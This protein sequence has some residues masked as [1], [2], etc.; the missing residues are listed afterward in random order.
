M[1]LGLRVL[2]TMCSCKWDD[3][4]ITE[5]AG[6]D[7]SGG[8]LAGFIFG[9][10]CFQRPQATFGGDGRNDVFCGFFYFSYIGGWLCWYPCQFA[11]HGSSKEIVWG[12]A[13]TPSPNGIVFLYLFFLDTIMSGFMF[14][15][16][17]SP[18]LS[19][20]LRKDRKIICAA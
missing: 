13:S 1:C 4:A 14:G 9:A 2:Q 17:C 20:N 7:G 3:P 10:G 19:E 11:G 12:R 18:Y 15:R 16:L 6:N 8:L 5:L